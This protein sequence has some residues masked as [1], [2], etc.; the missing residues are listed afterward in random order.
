MVLSADKVT[1]TASKRRYRRCRRRLEAQIQRS[2]STAKARRGQPV[3]GTEL[4]VTLPAYGPVAHV[5]QVEAMAGDAVSPPPRRT[6]MGQQPFGLPCSIAPVTGETK[7][8]ADVIN[9]FTSLDVNN[10][11]RMWIYDEQK[12][13]T[14]GFLLPLATARTRPTTGSFCPQMKFPRA[15]YYRL[16]MEVSAGYQGYLADTESFEIGFGK[17]A[18]APSLTVISDVTT[19]G[20]QE[21]LRALLSLSSK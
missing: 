1:W 8:A 11:K 7:L 16:S 5:A 18:H 6:H 14:G 15:G 3:R 2:P 9:L 20:A 17:E 19:L 21:G 12:E 13:Q 4:A 10:D